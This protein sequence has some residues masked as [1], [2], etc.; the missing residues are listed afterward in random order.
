MNGN[1]SGRQSKDEPAAANINVW[2]TEHVTQ[3]ST[4]GF[5]VQL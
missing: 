3:E 5:R 1:L 2:Q 4:I